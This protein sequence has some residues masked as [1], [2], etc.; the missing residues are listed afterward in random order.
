[1]FIGAE[2]Y[3]HDIAGQQPYKAEPVQC[4]AVKK[5]FF[6]T[7]AHEPVSLA[8]IVLDQLAFTDL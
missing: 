8:F 7:D 6:V 2:R 1:M 4:R 5:Y 3:S